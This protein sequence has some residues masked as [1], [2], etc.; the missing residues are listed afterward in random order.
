MLAVAGRGAAPSSGCPDRSRTRI[1]YYCSVQRYEL[2][3]AVGVTA[4]DR[5]RASPLRVSQAWLGG[6]RLAARTSGSFS[7]R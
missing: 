4:R 2:T 1:E 5:A 3:G 6:P 7:S